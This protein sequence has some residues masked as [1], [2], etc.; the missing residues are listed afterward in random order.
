MNN[1]IFFFKDIDSHYVFCLFGIRLMVKH[2]IK[3]KKQTISNYGLNTKPRDKS[4]IVSLTSYPARI[5]SVHETIITLLNQTVKPDKI[6]LWLS[7]DEFVDK[8]E[9]LPSELLALREYGLIINWCN[10]NIKSYKKLLPALEQYSNEII[11]TA[12]DDVYYDRFLIESLY[13]AY[14]KNPNYIYTRRAVEMDFQDTNLKYISPRKNYYNHRQEAS[15]LNQ[16]MGGSGC[17]YPPNSLH[18]DVFKIS[19]LPTHDDAYFG[20]MAVLNNTKIQIIDGYNRNL[21]FRK[22]TQEQ[23]LINLNKKNNSEG[24]ALEDAHKK[25]LEVYPEILEKI[26]CEVL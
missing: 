5:Q 3:V 19:L 24:I 26:K 20:A 2:P 6:I 22:G 9:N 1:K 7:E 14:L 10:K 25:I 4:I 11:I 16:Q 15:F 17:L 23:G 8:E 13:N 21:I 12:D 18:K